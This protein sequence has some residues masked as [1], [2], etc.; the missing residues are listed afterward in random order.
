MDK[1]ASDLRDLD[2][3]R[4]QFDVEGDDHAPTLGAIVQGAF[5]EIETEHFLERHGLRAELYFVRSVGL[6]SAALVLDRVRTRRL[7]A[8]LDRVSAADDAQPKGTDLQS[9]RDPYAGPI[10]EAARVDLFV[11][12]APFG[13]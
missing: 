3:D 9:A 4:A 10:F 8:K 7:A 1:S 13:G 12:Q 5:G 6:G 11:Q 2:G